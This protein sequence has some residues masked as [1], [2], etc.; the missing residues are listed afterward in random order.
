MPVGLPPDDALGCGICTTSD[1][2]LPSPSYSVDTVPSAAETQA[3]P[4][5][6][7]ARPQPLT[8]LGSV[9]AALMS[10][11][12]TSRCRW[13]TSL[14]SAGVAARSRASASGAHRRADGE[15]ESRGMGDSFIRTEC[16]GRRPARGAALHAFNPGVATSGSTHP[17]RLDH[18]VEGRA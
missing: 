12:E 7:K 3:K 16:G 9:C 18:D 17:W 15:G 8:R 13:N 6:L 1:C 4:K 10:P 5:G 14:A 2:T 11:S